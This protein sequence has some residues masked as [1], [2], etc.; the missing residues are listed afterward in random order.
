MDVGTMPDEHAGAAPNQFRLAEAA[1]GWPRMSRNDI[2][3]TT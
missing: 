2:G 3:S 1:T